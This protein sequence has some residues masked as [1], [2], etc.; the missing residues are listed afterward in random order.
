[1]T[2]PVRQIV[3][4]EVAFILTAIGIVVSGPH[5]AYA[6]VVAA[7]LGVILQALVVVDLVRIIRRSPA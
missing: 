4:S 2:K 7:T 5:P 3:L 1:M 6:Y